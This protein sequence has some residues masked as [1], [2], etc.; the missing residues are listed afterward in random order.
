MSL[1]VDKKMPLNSFVKLKVDKSA[2]DAI[3]RIQGESSCAIREALLQICVELNK[4]RMCTGVKKSTAGRTKNGDR[5]K[6]ADLLFDA[7]RDAIK[8]Q[9]KSESS[10]K[11][12]IKVK[13]N[14]I[15]LHERLDNMS[16]AKRSI[17]DQNRAAT[18]ERTNRR[19][20]EKQKIKK[21]D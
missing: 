17:Y 12:I 10:R 1:H 11:H 19:R 18:I 7:Y 15:N 6:Y 16:E 4:F 14:D 21:T 20:Y 3:R 5:T 8:S 2:V 9:R 13:Q